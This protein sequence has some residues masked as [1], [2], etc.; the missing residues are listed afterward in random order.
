M[1]WPRA[2]CA[3]L[4]LVFQ[5]S[6][7][8]AGRAEGRA[9]ETRVRRPSGAGGAHHLL[10]LPL[11]PLHPRSLRGGP[12]QPAGLRRGQG[13]G[14]QLRQGGHAP[15]HE[16]P[17]HLRRRRPGQDAPHGGHRQ[18]PAG[19]EPQAARG[20][21]QGGQLLQRAHRGHQGQEHRA[22]A[23]EVPAER[24][25]AAGRRAD[26]WEDGAHPG[27]DLLH[28]GIPAPARE[29][30]RPHLGQAA[31]SGWRAATSGSSPASSG[32]SRPTSSPRT[33]RPASPS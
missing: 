7:V 29:A 32:A 23:Q 10:P 5:V 27:G 1:P 13:R 11:Q 15:Q 19:A 26:P 17:V 2:A 16:S 22:H 21:P 18:G 4:Q 8:L 25:A 31:R 24:R 20:L 6:G 3:D 12:R 9:A 28:P 30:D 33:S 14:G